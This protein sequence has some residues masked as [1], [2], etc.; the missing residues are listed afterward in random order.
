MKHCASRKRRL[1]LFCGWILLTSFA[2]SNLTGKHCSIGVE[3]RENSQRTV[4]ILR[5]RSPRRRWTMPAWLCDGKKKVVKLV[6]VVAWLR[7]VIFDESWN[8]LSAKG[9]CLNRFWNPRVYVYIILFVKCS[10]ERALYNLFLH[11]CWNPATGLLFQAQELCA[12]TQLCPSSM[13]QDGQTFLSRRRTIYVRCRELSDVFL[14]VAKSI[15]W[16]FLASIRENCILAAL[17]PLFWKICS[18]IHWGT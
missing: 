1:V 5:T 4:T 14:G 17:Q 8:R 12:W 2:K 9:Y 7:S 18:W 16:E 10:L 6:Q 11:I 15:H 13:G 3:A